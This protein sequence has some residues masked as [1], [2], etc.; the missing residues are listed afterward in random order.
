MIQHTIIFSWIAGH[1]LLKSSNVSLIMKDIFSWKS[2]LLYFHVSHTCCEANQPIDYMTT[3]LCKGTWIGL[4]LLYLILSFLIFYRLKQVGFIIL[5]EAN[6]FRR[7]VLEYCLLITFD[8]VTSTIL[9]MLGP[10][11]GLH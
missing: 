2:G 3:K 7:S 5:E 6:M 10:Y 1:S 9:G 8:L 11:F 4:F